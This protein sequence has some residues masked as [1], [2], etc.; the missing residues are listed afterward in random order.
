RERPTNKAAPHPEPA[1]GG[2]GVFDA[3]LQLRYHTH[4]WFR[5][6]GRLL[7]QSQ[8]SHRTP[9]LRSSIAIIR[10]RESSRLAAVRRTA[11]FCELPLNGKYSWFADLH[12]RP[13]LL[14][15]RRGEGGHRLE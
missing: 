2:Q 10:C 4:R 1:G 6:F 3:Q 13:R 11:Q 7:Y 14:L 12:L 15:E 9:L 5:E 8:R